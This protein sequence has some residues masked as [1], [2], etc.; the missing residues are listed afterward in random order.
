[1]HVVAG[2]TK[3]KTDYKTQQDK[4][5]RS[6]TKVEY[7]KVLQDTLLPE[8]TKLFNDAGISD[9]FLQQDNDPCH[10][11][12]AQV[13]Q[14]WNDANGG[15][16]QLLPEWP[17][18]SPDLSIIENVWA[19]VQRQVNSLGCKDFE[20]FKR[21]VQQTFAGLHGET[22]ANLYKS[23]NKRMEAVVEREGGYTKY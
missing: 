15:N 4:P 12:A 23:M 20:G 18:S 13:V 10:N 17:P 3:H 21:A 2:T 11:V 9:W 22:V 6:I 14:G 5:A 7:K 19:L 1:M 16:V 8:G